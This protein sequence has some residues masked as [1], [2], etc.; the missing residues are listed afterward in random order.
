MSLYEATRQTILT[1]VAAFHGANYP[2]MEI[3]YPGRW[4]TNTETIEDPFVRVELN[5][6]SKGRSLPANHCRTVSG[7][8]GITHFA[9][10]NSGSSLFTLYTDA[11]DTYFGLKTISGITYY[12]V[13]PYGDSGK[14]G[15][16]GVMN[17]IKFE[18]DYFN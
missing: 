6:T 16:D 10:S 14:P 8:L 2:T 7:M 13:S 15:F 9:R 11:L 12:E 18:V 1:S 4:V 5:Y 17:V 3:N